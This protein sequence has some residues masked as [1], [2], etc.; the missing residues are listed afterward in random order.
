M[1]VTGPRT[2]E[3]HDLII[4]QQEREC[5]TVLARA[6]TKALSEGAVVVKNFAV[7]Q[8]YPPYKHLQDILESMGIEFHSVWEE[9]GEEEEILELWRCRREFT[10]N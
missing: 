1:K 4:Q 10:E 3:A 5:F 6:F 9:D 8:K 7:L 2:K